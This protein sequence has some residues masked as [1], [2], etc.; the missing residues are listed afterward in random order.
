MNSKHGAYLYY[1]NRLVMKSILNVYTRVYSMHAGS[2]QGRG[3]KKKK[4]QSSLLA[5]ISASRMSAV[6]NTAPGFKQICS[7]SVW[8]PR[9]ARTLHACSNVCMSN[10]RPR[11]VKVGVRGHKHQD[12]P[13]S[14]GRLIGGYPFFRGSLFRGAFFPSLP[15]SEGQSSF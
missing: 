15:L 11:R 4:Q 5:N 3:R 2:K 12:S 6:I 7:S 9:G 13:M 1:T 8:S 10:W 14:V